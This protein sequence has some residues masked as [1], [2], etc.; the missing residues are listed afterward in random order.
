MACEGFE[1][2]YRNNQ[3]HK[4]NFLSTMGAGFSFSELVM[5]SCTCISIILTRP[6]T[7]NNVIATPRNNFQTSSIGPSHTFYHGALGGLDA[8]TIAYDQ[9]SSGQIDAA[10][11]GAPNSIIDPKLSLQYVGLNYLSP[12]ALCRAF[13]EQGECRRLFSFVYST[14]INTYYKRNKKAFIFFTLSF[15]TCTYAYIC[16]KCKSELGVKKLGMMRVYRPYSN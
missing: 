7:T 10:L 15:H 16:T 3:N 12:D 9:I 6:Y 11:V 1:R 8:M 4:I 5:Y 2:T 13:D 14:L